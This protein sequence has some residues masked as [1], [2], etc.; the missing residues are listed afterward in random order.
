MRIG[1]MGGRLLPR[2]PLR[3]N[4]TV[5]YAVIDPLEALTVVSDF[6]QALYREAQFALR[7]AV[8]GRVLDK[9]L[10]DK[11]ALG[12]EIQSTVADRVAGMGV[13]VRS[14]GLR[15]VIRR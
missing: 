14:I 10:A 8:G 12:A 15:D 9:V 1:A 3:V 6:E 11:E 7:A 4:L 13:A 5:T 2:N